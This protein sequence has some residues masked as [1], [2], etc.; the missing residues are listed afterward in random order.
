MGGSGERLPEGSVPKGSAIGLF[1]RRE[2]LRSWNAPAL[3]RL[4]GRNREDTMTKRMAVA[5]GTLASLV[6][7]TGAIF[8]E[9]KLPPDKITYEAKPGAVTFD[10]VKHV[11]AAK[12]DCKAC[13]DAIFPQSKAPLAYKD[14]MHKKAETDK[15]SC[16]ACHVAGGA[17][18]ESKGNCQK[19]HVKTPA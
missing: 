11:E 13:H 7:M 6:F 17:A 16:G 14:S 3:L 18:F 1:N 19:C 4:P 15:T 12:K 5:V 9:G 8:A 2:R 10:H